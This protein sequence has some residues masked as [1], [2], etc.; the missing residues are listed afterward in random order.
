MARVHPSPLCSAGILARLPGPVHWCVHSRDL[1]APAL[2]RVG[3]HP[4]SVIYCETSK[5]AEVLPAMEEGLRYGGLAGVVGE[6]VR[7]PLMLSRRLRLA[8]ETSGVIALA[9]RRSGR[10]QDQA[11]A[12]FSSWRIGPL[13]SGPMVDLNMGRALATRVGGDNE[14]FTLPADR[15][16]EVRH[17]GGPDPRGDVPIRKVRDIYIP[18]LHIDTLALRRGFSVM[19]VKKKTSAASTIDCDTALTHSKVL[20]WQTRRQLSGPT[21]R[22]TR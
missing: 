19:I 10:Q 1:F 22:G 16:D 2:A 7:L 17:P 18:D 9:M 4:D 11:N 6:L 20:P 3:L 8:A 14:T 15:G 21:P 5:D 13:P 12:C